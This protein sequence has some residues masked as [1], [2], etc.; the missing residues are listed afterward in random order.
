MLLPGWSLAATMV[1]DGD[2][3]EASCVVRDVTVGMAWHERQLERVVF[4][5]G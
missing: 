3:A 5:R 1:D 4:L 2:L